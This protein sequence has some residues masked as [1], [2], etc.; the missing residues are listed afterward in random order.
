VAG[1]PNQL[2]ALLFRDYLRVNWPTASAYANVKRE[3]ARH[4][5]EDRD[6]YVLTK[7]PVCDL[8]TVAAADWAAR[9]S[10]APGSSDA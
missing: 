5:P 1:R 10:W 2:Y 6:A 7:D 4:H 3:L 9:T 8:I